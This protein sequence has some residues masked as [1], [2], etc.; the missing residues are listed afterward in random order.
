[1][2]RPRLSP[3]D[4][5]APGGEAAA[6]PLLTSRPPSGWTN[7]CR[8]PFKAKDAFFEFLFSRAPTHYDELKRKAAA[9]EPL[10]SFRLDDVTL[11]FNV[12]ADYEVVR[13]QLTQNV[14]GI[15]EG[16]DPELKTTYV[17]FGAHYDHVG[18]AEGEVVNGESGDR[19]TRAPGPHHPGR[20]RRSH[21][22]RRRR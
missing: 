15:V 9:R 1:M 13:T 22:E 3:A 7:H 11:T 18:Y 17:A 5:A 10:P 21:L 4:L 14:V 2:A 20:R 6:Y 19:R 16:S 8:Q 12:D